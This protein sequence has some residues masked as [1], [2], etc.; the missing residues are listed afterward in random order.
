MVIA[1]E[2][3]VFVSRV[4][5]LSGINLKQYR[6]NYLRRRVDLRMKMVGVNNYIQYLRMLERDRNE[7]DNLI[8]TITINVTEFMRD[9]TPFEFF[10]N[11][12]LPEIA[13][14]KRV[15]RSNLLRFWSA[16]CSYGEEPYSIA[17]CVYEVLGNGWTVSIYATDIDDN[18]L[19]SAKEGLY[20]PEQ[21][22]NLDKA[23]I[24]KYFE[25]EDGVYKIKNFV[26]KFVR[27]KKHD[28]TTEPP[29]SKYFDAIF[30]R[31]VMIYFNENQK[32]KIMNDFYE[33]LTK[34]GYLIIGKSETLPTSFKDKFLAVN[35]KE[36]VYVKV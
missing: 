25:K 13:K 10:M 1:D 31:N 2:F 19:K 21:L 8:N 30:C 23:M 12:I 27:F 36:K 35:L 6:D 16:G 29:I 33:A 32:T 24:H 15:A 34:D 3:S 7:L 4:S 28:L 22:R 9:K 26:K 14:R 18:C 17:I 5:S 20:K 11:V